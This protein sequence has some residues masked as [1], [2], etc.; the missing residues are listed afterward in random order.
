MLV[1]LNWDFFGENCE[2][3]K[4]ICEQT[5]KS[6]TEDVLKYCFTKSREKKLA[7]PVKIVLQSFSFTQ[8]TFIKLGRVGPIFNRPSP[9]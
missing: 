6:F 4:F 1:L 7:I 3:P 5:L 9:D 8:Y 2:F